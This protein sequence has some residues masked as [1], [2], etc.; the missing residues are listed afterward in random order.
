MI[1]IS[2]DSNTPEGLESRFSVKIHRIL[3]ELLHSTELELGK[4]R[5]I[6][7]DSGR[8]ST[9]ELLRGLSISREVLW[10][11]EPR[12]SLYS[13]RTKLGSTL[14]AKLTLPSR[15]LSGGVGGTYRGI[16]LVLWA[17]VGL[18]GTTC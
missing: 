10:A 3:V 9:L 15:F 12:L 4:L 14:E 5:R 11:S 2:R 18:E 16:K 8:A 6:R 1:P 7:T 13:T 17:K